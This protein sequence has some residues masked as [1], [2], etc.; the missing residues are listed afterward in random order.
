M[1][2]KHLTIGLVMLLCIGFM[3]S[4]Y[5][6]SLG[7]FAII[8]VS[9]EMY[10]NYLFNISGEEANGE[11]KYPNAFSVDR[12]YINTSST[13]SDKVA[14]RFTTDVDP[15]IVDKVSQGYSLLV[16]YAYADVS[17]IIPL[18]KL[19]L[20]LQG[21][22]YVGLADKAWGYRVVSKSL[23]DQYKVMSS[24]DLGLGATVTAPQGYGELVLQ[25]LNGG[26][27]KL[28]ETNTS[29]AL[30]ARLLLTPL[31]QNEML[32]GLGVAG[33]VYMDKDDNDNAKDRYAGMLLYKY[34]IVNF[35]GEFG[36]SQDG[37]DEVKGMGYS[38]A[39][40]VKLPVTEGPLMN[41]A[42]LCR[43]DSWDKNTD[44][45]KD[46]VM[47]IIAG[48]S[49]E[50]SKGVKAIA[51]F[52]NTDDKSKDKAKQDVVGQLYVKSNNK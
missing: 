36:M 4:V 12:V 20:G 46:E 27:Y 38:A 18:T 13:L 32:K 43:L 10:L 50:I 35:I 24:A 51:T 25:A 1:K 28:L 5:A 22:S 37:K 31:P 3:G 15:K 29:K 30:S 16:K 21:N 49:Y 19:T 45:E 40:E 34:S 23:L 42:F 11:T 41:L 17:N 44:K 14:F 26:G 33:L 2:I 6:A 8:S 47:R 39:A 9:G 48:L 7:K 52:Q